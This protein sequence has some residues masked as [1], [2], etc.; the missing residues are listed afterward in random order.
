MVKVIHLLSS[1]DYSGA[2]N[3]VIKI[4]QNMN[5]IYKNKYNFIYASKSGTIDEVLD[6]E[7]IRHIIVSS[8]NLY[9]IS[10]IIKREMPDIIH[11][12]DF[13]A[14]IAA[15]LFSNRVPVI[16]HLHNNPGWIKERNFKSKIYDWSISR[17]SKIILVS[18]AISNEYVYSESFE[19]KAIVLGNPIVIKNQL[20][21][22]RD[23]DVLFVGRLTKQKNPIRF[24]EICGNLPNNFKCVMLGRGELDEE[25][26]TY[27]KE[28]NIRNVELIGFKQDAISYMNRAKVLLITSEWEGFGM[29]ATEALEVGT[30]VISTNVGGLPTI[31][32]NDCGYLYSYDQEAVSEIKHLVS[33]KT[34]WNQKS[35]KA[36]ERAKVLENIREYCDNLDIIYSNI[37]K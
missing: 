21:A 12:H 20:N 32:T 11:A 25:C 23:I 4:I 7:K 37:I 17:Y 3:V 10:R 26:F 14:S 2:E 24:I 30:P 15:S 27:I 31:V 22:L 8:L 35:F 34:Y 1:S 9:Q 5:Y 6:K 13:K 28:H 19:N 33:D 16:S 29:V 18:N 36:K